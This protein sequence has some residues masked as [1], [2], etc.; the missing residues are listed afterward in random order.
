MNDLDLLRQYEPIVRY[1]QGEMFFPCAVDE[2]IKG[3]SLW[4]VDPEGKATELAPGGT[5]TVDNLSDHEE[6]PDGH[7]MYLTY[8]GEALDPLEYQRWTRR[9][10]RE[11]FHASGR[12]ARVPLISRIGDSL[13][14]LSLLVRGSVPGGVAAAADIKYRELLQR[15]PRRVYYGRVL[16]EGGWIVLHYLFYFTM[17]NWRSNFYGVNDHES[18]WEQVFIYLADEGD[19]PEPRWAAFASH[20][21][22]G[23]DLR[24]RWDDPGFVRA[25]NHPVIYAGAGSHASYFEEGEYIMGATP[26][27][28]KPL[29]NGIIALTR[30]WNEQLGQGSNMISVKEA[31]NLISIPFVDYARGDGK[32]I[33]PGQDEEWSPV[34][35]SD[36]DGWVDRYRGLW[37]LDTRDPFGGERAPAGPKYDRDGSVRHSWYDPLGWAGLDKVYPP[38]ATLAELDTRLAALVDEEAAL[39]AEIQALRTQVRNLGL[40]VEALRAAEYFS[41][42]HESREEQLTSLQVQLQNL[43]SALI[44]NQETQKSLRAYRARA[45][46]GDWGS[47]TAHLKHVHPPA[48]PLP[49]QRRV[50]EIW[51]AISGAL[52]LLIFVALLIFRP[53]HWPFWA[54]VAGIAFG[55]VESMTR[56]RLSNFMLTTVIVLALLATLILFIEFWRWI[57]LLALV[58]IVVYM[59]RDNLREVLRA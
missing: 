16:R 30:F 47:P 40:D 19:E 22:S 57:L 35:I 43:R 3:A 55:A 21:F 2:F 44:S 1:T 8:A 45:Q 33:G 12:L 56:G 11:P 51:A 34:L 10:D 20:D 27:V 42:L 7:T 46:A 23:D 49:P 37:G 5:L 6:I 59:I 17:N 53:M 39:S 50:V 26:A 18:D 52:A 38:Q 54:V 25:G 58:G 28:L 32:S 9:T 31:G 13:F 4:L 48:P 24:R 14:D 15:D 29:Q 41:T 36:A